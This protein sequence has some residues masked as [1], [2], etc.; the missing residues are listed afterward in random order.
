MDLP[1]GTQEQTDKT[2]GPKSIPFSLLSLCSC[3]QSM[4]KIKWAP[5]LSGVKQR[6]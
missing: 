4:P 1:A 3:P 5:W 6:K 2:A